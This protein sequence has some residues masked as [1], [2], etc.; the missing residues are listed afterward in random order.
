MDFQSLEIEKERFGSNKGN[1]KG[2]ITFSSDDARINLKLNQSH[3]DKIFE[4]VA[5]TMIEVAK[6]AA[7]E[8]TVNIIEH[9]EVLKLD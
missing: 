4:I 3:I 1:L 5:D 6:E 8:L 2:N 7:Q 9:K